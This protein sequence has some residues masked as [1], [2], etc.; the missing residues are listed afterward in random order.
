MRG[1]GM[2]EF[3]RQIP[4]GSMA[5]LATLV[6]DDNQIGDQGMIAFSNAIS[7]G[8]LP[9]VLRELYLHENQIDDE[10]MKALSAAISSGSRGKLRYQYTHAY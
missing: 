3:S 1:P 7:N 4:I 5:N 8:S 2:I 6:L 10:G 9:G